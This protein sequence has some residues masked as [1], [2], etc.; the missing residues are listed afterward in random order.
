MVK[1]RCKSLVKTQKINATAETTCENF[2]HIV[3]V[4]R[5]EEGRMRR[6][7]PLSSG[8][9][10]GYQSNQLDS[11]PWKDR[12]Q[13]GVVFSKFRLEEAIVLRAR[14]DSK[15]RVYMVFWRRGEKLNFSFDCQQ[16]DDFLLFLLF[17][18]AAG[19]TCNSKWGWLDFLWRRAQMPPSEEARVTASFFA[20]S[21]CTFAD[22]MS[23]LHHTFVSVS[24]VFCGPHLPDAEN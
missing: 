20:S 16:N 9:R 3:G 24:M 6:D 21:A 11:T 12:P 2:A 7:W 15:P 19:R 4:Y 8:L 22:K 10:S 1:V 17:S 14:F 18:V 13:E 23:S 5:L